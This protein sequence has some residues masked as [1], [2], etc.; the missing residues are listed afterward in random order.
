LFRDFLK[1]H[2]FNVPRSK[3]F[4]DR[5][6]ARTWLSDIGIPAF[7][8]P[9]D[10]SG[11]KGVTQLINASGFDRAF[12]FALS[13]SR[14]KMVVVEEPIQRVGY[15]IDS[16]VFM[17]GGKLAFWVWANQHNDPE[18]HP[19]AP[20]GSSFPSV[21]RREVQEAAAR[22]VEQVLQILGFTHGAFNVEFL[23]DSEDNVWLL[24]IG[25]RNGGNG[26]PNAIRYATGIDLVKHTVDAALGMTCSELTMK[27][28]HGYWGAYVVHAMESG[29]YK[30]L[31]LSKRAQRRIVEQDIWLAP[32]SR[33][34]KFNGSQD[35]VGLMVLRFE[36]R[37]EMLEM[38][39]NMQRDIRVEAER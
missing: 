19:Y 21:M 6:Q 36:S 9:V 20:I 11:S 2:G 33:V 37:E 29:V 25:P 13:F 24:E 15:E 17:V 34:E 27:P 12:D 22:I 4:H 14:E 32:G 28:P 10:S 1:N 26:I 35:I 31:W 23:V 3:S 16:D 8:K 5:E 18:C 39:D 7:V 38:M 30:G